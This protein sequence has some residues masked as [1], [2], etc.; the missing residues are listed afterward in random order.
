MLEA[1]V[2]GAEAVSA[3][4]RAETRVNLYQSV[5]QGGTASEHQAAGFSPTEFGFGAVFPTAN[6]MSMQLGWRRVNGVPL[7]QLSGWAASGQAEKKAFDRVDKFSE[8]AL[9]HECH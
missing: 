7:L 3:L 6:F 1:G 5:N 2:G 9:I 8:G 4:W